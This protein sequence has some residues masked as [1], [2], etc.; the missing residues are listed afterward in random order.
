[1]NLLFLPGSFLAREP[2][3]RSRPLGTNQNEPER[4]GKTPLDARLFRLARVDF[5]WVWF[6][7]GSFWFVLVRGEYP[8]SF[9]Y[10]LQSARARSARTRT[11]QKD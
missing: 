5:I 6:V 10:V 1:M 11:N 7:S 3:I 8:S 9:L 2:S 4:L